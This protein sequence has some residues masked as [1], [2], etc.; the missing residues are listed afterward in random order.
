M[1]QPTEER[2]RIHFDSISEANAASLTLV[3]PSYIEINDIVPD[4]SDVNLKAALVYRITHV[5]DRK[6]GNGSSVR[7]F[8]VV[9]GDESGIIHLVAREDQCDFFKEKSVVEI[10]GARVVF[11]KNHIVLELDQW[12]KVNPVSASTLNDSHINIDNNISRVIFEEE[13]TG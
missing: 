1:P 7:I 12:S 5:F 4:L 9:L 8:D 3:K 13:E 2:I 10:L 6:A 11:Y